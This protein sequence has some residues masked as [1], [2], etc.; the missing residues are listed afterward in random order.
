MRRLRGRERRRPDELS[1]A[2][3]SLLFSL[4][5]HE[6]LPSSELAHAADLAPA[7]ATEM[8]DALAEHGLVQ[9]ARSERDRRVVLVSLTDRGHALVEERH[10]RFE[11][12]WRAALAEF[13]DTELRTAAAVLERLRALFDEIAEDKRA[14][15]DPGRQLAVEM[16]RRLAASATRTHP[17]LRLR[18]H[19]RPGLGARSACGTQ[20]RP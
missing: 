5:E 13:S 2:Q 18:A 15:L 6:A 3:Y 7:T 12:R 10:A 1:D 8:L 11:P 14:P 20:P 16:R 19:D 4:R 9:R 17:R